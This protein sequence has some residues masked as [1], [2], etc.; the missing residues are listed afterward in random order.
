MSVISEL[1]MQP[2]RTRPLT[3]NPG[4]TTRL[5]IT[6]LVSFTL[7]VGA[8]LATPLY[9]QL[10]AELSLGAMGT[11]IA[12]ASYVCSLMFFLS[13]VGHW[14]DHIGRRAALVLAII[15]SLV[16]TLSFGAASALW[17]LCLGR[18]LQGAGVALATGASAAA[19][20]EL[21]PHK[22]EWASRFTLL[23]SSGGVAFGPL[24]GGVLALLPGGRT[25]VF[26]VQAVLLL[27][28]LIPLVALQARPAIAMAE[29]GQRHRAL[30]PRRLGIPR[31]ARTKF[32]MG[33]LVGFLS[34]AVFGFALSLAPGYFAQVF[35]LTSLPMI[36]LVAGL[37][38]GISALSQV[39][40]RG[41][42]R[43]LP[44]GLL[45]LAASTI[46]LVVAAELGSLWLAMLALALIGLGQGIA[47]RTA[48][49]GA[50]NAVSASLHAQT[51]STIYLVTYLGSALPVIVLGW[52]VGVYGQELSIL[53]F[54]VLCALLALL[55]TGWSVASLAKDRTARA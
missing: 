49:S 38:L 50:V 14:S 46:G 13:I 28:T 11:T 40:I 34:F 37:P 15:I 52:A 3:W 30:A 33:A 4:T 44:L 43:L 54:S 12:F 21:L 39:V 2:V 29:R 36:G 18:G 32:W 7:L 55:L 9:P 35:E 17:E 53:V 22:P 27:A 48:F 23:A 5:S 47:F 8:N 25:T 16:G 10:Q 45:L 1:R 31:E 24:L 51:V 42:Q 41:G 26:T 19:L 20:R 6:V